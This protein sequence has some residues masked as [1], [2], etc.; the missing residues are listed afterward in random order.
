MCK[1]CLAPSCGQRHVRKH[2]Q[3]LTI[4]KVT[5]Q[6]VLIHAQEGQEEAINPKKTD[7]IVNRVNKLV[8]CHLSAHVSVHCIFKYVLKP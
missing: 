6:T 4:L 8:C 3:K 5:Q 2:R 7:Y 1:C